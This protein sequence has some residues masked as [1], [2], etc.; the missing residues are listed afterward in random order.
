MMGGTHH[1]ALDR[2]AGASFTVRLPRIQGETRRSDR[3][4]SAFRSLNRPCD[5]LTRL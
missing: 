4:L 3:S 5:C 1:R 2:G